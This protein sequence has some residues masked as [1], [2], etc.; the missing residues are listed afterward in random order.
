VTAGGSYA[1]YFEKCAVVCW[2]DYYIIAFPETPSTYNNKMYAYHIPTGTWC[3]IGTTDHPVNASCLSVWDGPG[4]NGELYYGDAVTGCVYRLF[5]KT[6][7]YTLWSQDVGNQVPLATDGVNCVWRSGAIQHGKDASKEFNVKS[8]VRMFMNF[9][10]PASSQTILVKTYQRGDETTATDAGVT[11]TLSSAA[12]TDGE[13]N[14]IDVAPVANAPS[15]QIG[16]TGE[17]TKTVV[18]EGYSLTYVE[19]G[20]PTS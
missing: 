4:D 20:N 18:Q 3:E 12:A 2:R 7:A 14:Y 6:G 13:R 9:H 11:K 15:F 19:K 5:A 1:D 16:W 17:F 8:P 10:E